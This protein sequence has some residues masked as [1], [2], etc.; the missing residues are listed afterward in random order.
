V[1]VSAEP[2]VVNFLYGVA[3]CGA[4]AIAA[5]FLRYWRDTGDRFFLLFAMAFVLLSVDWMSIVALRP[6]ADVRHL[7]YLWRL[8]AF[9]M[10]G[11]AIWDKNRSRGPRE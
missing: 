11:G 8:A 3:V 10:I 2:A 1:T 7:T 9:V 4:W 5:F 6:A